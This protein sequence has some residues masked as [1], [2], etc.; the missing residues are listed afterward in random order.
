MENKLHQKYMVGWNIILDT[1]N[2]KLQHAFFSDI[3]K[4]KTFSASNKLNIYTYENEILVQ[5]QDMKDENTSADIKKAF[6][7]QNQVRTITNRTLDILKGILKYSIN[8]DEPF[9]MF[10]DLDYKEIFYSLTGTDKNITL[11]KN[12]AI[13]NLIVTSDITIGA[14]IEPNIDPQLNLNKALALLTLIDSEEDAENIACQRS[15][16]RPYVDGSIISEIIYKGSVTENI[17][18]PCKFKE[19]TQTANNYDASKS[20]G[21]HGT[22]FKTLKENKIIS[23]TEAESIIN[24]MIDN[25]IEYKNISSTTK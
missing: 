2:S 22:S 9:N 18:K 1:S 14:N 23:P 19:F 3:S 17:E 6:S 5:H 4:A 25:Y 12:P 16:D 13:I 15:K 24:D 11:Y 8:F 20:Y 7:S 21:R 10:P